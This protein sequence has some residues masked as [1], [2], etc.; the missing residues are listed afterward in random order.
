MSELE[1]KVIP[2]LLIS[3]INNIRASKTSPWPYAYSADPPPLVKLKN[4][5]LFHR[6]HDWHV[7]DGIS[8]RAYYAVPEVEMGRKI[9]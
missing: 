2:I 1:P 5:D 6:G 7:V 4:G 9:T 3:G 8:H